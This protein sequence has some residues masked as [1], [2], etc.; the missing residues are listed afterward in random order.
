[1]TTSV[2]GPRRAPNGSAG[3]K[4]HR[5]INCLSVDV[6]GF[7]ESNVQSFCIGKEHFGASKENAEIERNIDALLE[8][9][10]DTGVKATFFFVA[11]IARD[12][13]HVVDRVARAGHE[14]GCHNYEHV[15]LW[16]IERGH[17]AAKL[18]SAKHRLEDTVGDSILGFRAPD[19]SISGSNLWALDVLRELG[20]AYDSSIYPIGMH[21]VYGMA[22]AE[23][24]VHKLPNGLIEF[25]LS[26]IRIAGKN[27]PF[28][29]GGYF[30]LYPLF[31]TAFCIARIN[32]LGHP[33]MFYVHP[34]EVGPVIPAV[35]GLSWYRRFRHYHNCRHGKARLRRLLAMH[36]F[37]SARDILFKMGLLEE[38]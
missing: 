20:F 16:D 23:R 15:R 24:F 33:C 30:R 17:L 34:Y 3:E 10:D 6:E 1:M 2:P 19:F 5:V 18:A 9:L 36:R 38:V 25:P 26:T 32:N 35:P 29:G 13:P 27:F 31:L 28:G 14:V 37:G 12:I 7:L 22:D 4:P 11:R 8:L 21:D